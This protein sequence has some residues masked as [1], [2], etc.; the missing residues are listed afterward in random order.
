MTSEEAVAFVRRTLGSAV[1]AERLVTAVPHQLFRVFRS[2]A[3]GSVLVCRLEREPYT[4]PSLHAGHVER[5]IRDVRALHLF[6]SRGPLRRLQGP[7]VVPE[8]II[9][10]LRTR[11]VVLEDVLRGRVWSPSVQTMASVGRFVASLHGCGRV[12]S[13]HWLRRL[14]RNGPPDASCLVFG[15]LTV[16]SVVVREGRPPCLLGWG[17]ARAGRPSDDL[18]SFAAS[19]WEEHG[20]QGLSSWRAFIKTYRESAPGWSAEEAGLAERSARARAPELPEAW[21]AHYGMRS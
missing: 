7:A 3:V 6:S 19:L 8:V 11:T 14:F 12:D 15:A 16:D 17:S 9:A 10:E 20:D 18:G 13:H 1:H 4:E 21:L 2:G 5:L